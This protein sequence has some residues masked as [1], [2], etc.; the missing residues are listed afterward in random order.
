MLLTGSL[1]GLS[2][3]DEGGL[4]LQVRDALAAAVAETPAQVPV[5]V[6]PPDLVLAPAL[7]PAPLSCSKPE[8]GESHAL[9]QRIFWVATAGR[10][11]GG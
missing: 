5:P 9:R 1:F 7:A 2:C 8:R 4:L 10:R 3:G 6:L 11:H